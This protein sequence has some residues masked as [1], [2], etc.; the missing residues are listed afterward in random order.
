MNAMKT[1]TKTT[2]LALALGIAPLSF[3]ADLPSESAK[4]IGK[5][6]SPYQQL[7]SA[8]GYKADANAVRRS[9]AAGADPNAVV[10]LWGTSALEQA[11]FWGHTD[12]M[13]MLI[14]AGADYRRILAGHSAM[15][16]AVRGGRIDGV[17]LL[18][19][20]GVDINAPCGR[21]NATP[22][23]LATQSGKADLINYLLDSGADVNARDARGRTALFYLSNNSRPVAA[24]RA[25]LAAGADINVRDAE[26]YTPLL[27]SPGVLWSSHEY[28][29]DTEILQMYLD[30]GADINA[31]TDSGFNALELAMRS[32]EPSEKIIAFLAGKGLSASLEAQL[33]GAAA[34]GRLED[35]KRLLAAGASPNPVGKEKGPLSLCMSRGTI[36]VPNSEEIMKALLAAGADPNAGTPLKDSCHGSGNC[37]NM[38]LEAG[39]DPNALDADDM[40]PLLARIEGEQYKELIK[41]LAKYGCTAMDAD[42]IAEKTVKAVEEN[43]LESLIQLL[44]IARLH[45]GQLCNLLTQAAAL[46]RTDVIRL[47]LAAPGIDVNQTDDKGRTPIAC[48]SE[49]G[50][51]EAV[52]IL[53]AAGADPNSQH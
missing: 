17:K 11:A 48:A 7:K 53:L 4:A 35:V 38:L 3:C 24:A 28:Y 12:I 8:V 9:L 22:L 10:N 50:N 43:D 33:Q 32:D 18:A 37:F 30:A 40:I 52:R 46:G 42:Q 39:A 20:L 2:L 21:D 29:R 1:I 26:G 51:Q 34:Q 31:R 14:D 25:L 49:S 16:N 13:R 23:M 19:S 44:P 45:S 47:I 15:S 27:A 41:L 36:Y 5:S 6:V